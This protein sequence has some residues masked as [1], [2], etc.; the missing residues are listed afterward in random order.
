MAQFIDNSFPYNGDAATVDMFM[1]ELKLPKC[2]RPVTIPRAITKF[3]AK[4]IRSKTALERAVSLFK[5][6]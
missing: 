6:P 5:L 4:T 3:S 2:A 1:K